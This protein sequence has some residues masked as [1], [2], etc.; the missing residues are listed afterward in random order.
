MASKKFAVSLQKQNICIIKM[1]VLS[2]LLGIV[3][4]SFEVLNILFRNLWNQ[5]HYKQQLFIILL[6]FQ[7]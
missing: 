7:V 1:K 6:G 3:T 5:T 2:S 4:I